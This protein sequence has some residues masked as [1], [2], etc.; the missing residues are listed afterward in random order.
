MAMS[1]FLAEI[2]TFFLKQQSADRDQHLNVFRSSELK[3]WKPFQIGKK[4]YLDIKMKKSSDLVMMEAY[5]SEYHVTGNNT[6]EKTF[7]GRYFGWPVSKVSGTVT[8]SYSN[9]VVHNDPAYAPFTPPYFEGEAILRFELS[10]ASASYNTV[11]DLFNDLRL[12][13]IFNELGQSA[14]TASEAYLNK[15]SIQDCMEVFGIG[16]NP[17]S[18]FEANGTARSQDA[19]PN[20]QTQYWAISPKL[21]TPVLDFSDQEFVAH[22]G[23]YWVS[24]GYGRG[25][26]SGYGKIPTGSKGITIEMAESFPLQNSGRFNNFTNPVNPKLTGSLLDQVGFKAQ[27]SK[28]GQLAETKDISE[29]IVAIPYVDKAI[30]GVT[31]FVDG[32]HFISIDE[33]IYRNFKN[34]IDNKSPLIILGQSQD[35]DNSIAKMIIA[36]DKYVI[37]PNLNFS[38]YT[39]IDPFVMYLF[40]FKHTLD[41]QD[42]ADIWQ[43][44]MPKIA[45]KAEEDQVVI[46]H[47]FGKYELFGENYSTPE[48][49]RW[50][51]FKVKKKAEWNYF[52]ITEN[53]GDDDRFQFN[54]ANS[55][56]AQTPDYSYNWPYDYFSLVELAKVDITMEYSG[57]QTMPLQTA[58]TIVNGNTTPLQTAVT[59]VDSNTTATSTNPMTRRR[60]NTGLSLDTAQKTAG[61]FK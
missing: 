34:S 42:L 2:P 53:I 44:V 17:V 22:T 36:M 20:T 3:N 11:R 50:M 59:I 51:I 58:I 8:S 14:H 49:L 16:A 46:E 21:E 29:A 27:S 32:H 61:K 18:T 30:D 7:N 4:Y 15:M 52:A 47:K 10:A 54:F 57:S 40:E 9:Y 33:N 56:V 48:N 28:I 37:P 38:K 35:Y 60:A 26:W 31:T 43:G 25:M 24:S 13:D 55:Q 19:T 41:Q 5:R 23:S 39:N 12:T 1:N 6:I 45:Y